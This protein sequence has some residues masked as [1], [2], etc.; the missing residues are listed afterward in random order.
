MVFPGLAVK[1]QL[2]RRSSECYSFRGLLSR[3][4]SSAE[5]LVPA[6]QDLPFSLRPR[7][8]FRRAQQHLSI[9]LKDSRY[10]NTSIR[11]RRGRESLVVSML[12]PNNTLS[13]YPGLN[14]AHSEHRQRFGLDLDL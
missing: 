5:D 13:L 7:R 10:R 2:E 6:I 9:D 12:P 3:H 4:P 1:L 11:L 14:N 8:N